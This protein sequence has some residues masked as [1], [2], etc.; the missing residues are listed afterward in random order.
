MD[1]NRRWAKERGLP[2]VEGHRAGVKAL[3]NLVRACPNHGIEYLT[4]YAFS[5]E[6]W[7]RES[8]ELDFLFKLLGE[9][10]VRELENLHKENVRVSFIGDINA[11]ADIGIKGNLERLVETTK[12]NTGLNL[13]IALNYGSLDELSRALKTIKATLSNDDIE[14]LTEENFN[15]YLY[16]HNIPDPEII[17]RT[18]GEKRLS[19]FLLWQG[20]N[21]HL[22]FVDTLWPDF[23]NADLE[24]VLSHG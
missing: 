9:V 15:A 10:A 2:S 20:A 6:N 12:N 1:G 13:Q 22:S 7:K 14:K 5:T 19:N 24:K 3:K 4:V 18:G 21:A 11:F 23:G 8:N 16:T 17:L